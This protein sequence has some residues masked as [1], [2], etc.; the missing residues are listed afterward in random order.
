MKKDYTH[1]HVL[2]DR[3]GSMAGHETDVDGWYKKF[4]EEQK[5]LAG[6]C[7][8]SIAQFDSQG[9]DEVVGWSP[10]A[11]IPPSYKLVARGGT[12]LLDSFARSINDLGRKLSDIKEDE[13]PS[14]VLVIVQT[15]GE[16]NSSHEYDNEKLKALVNQQR[17]VYKWEFVFI[18]ADIDAFHQGGQIGVASGS[19]LNTGNN[20]KGY[21]VSSV[22][23]SAAVARWRTGMTGSVAY[24]ADEQNMAQATTTVKAS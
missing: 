2:F 14:K 4:F 24:N 7:T 21:F 9:Y 19:T 11:L 20:S 6:E 22:V 8:V 13:R 1:I 12:P 5:K 10:I 23:T 17:D 3:S 15:D 16:E 18:G